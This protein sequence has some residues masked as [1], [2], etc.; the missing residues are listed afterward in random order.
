MATHWDHEHPHTQ[1]HHDA[2]A[3][4]V[5]LLREAANEAG[6]IIRSE[7]NVIKLELQESTRAVVVDALKASLYT[8]VALLGILSLLAFAI[9]GLAALIAGGGTSVMS[10]WLSALIIGVLFTA[11]GGLMAAR[12]MVRVGGDARFKR[13][14]AEVAT[15]KRF[16]KDE[17]RHIKNRETS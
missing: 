2:N 3:S 1:D 6:E 10:F 13:T 4:L 7:A 12:H 8:A 17:W 5:E 14:R 16:V 9:I 11:A 15:D